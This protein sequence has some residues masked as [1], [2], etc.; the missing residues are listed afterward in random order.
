MDFKYETC[1]LFG[2]ICL[3]GGYILAKG[4]GGKLSYFCG[5]EVFV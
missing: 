5:A 1:G 4:G 3:S 2:C